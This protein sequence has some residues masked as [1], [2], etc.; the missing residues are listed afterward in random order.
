ME[1][2]VRKNERYFDIGQ[3][4]IKMGIELDYDEPTMISHVIVK[5]YMKDTLGGHINHRVRCGRE[6]HPNT[7]N[8]IFGVFCVAYRE[9]WKKLSYQ[10]FNK[11]DIVRIYNVSIEMLDLHIL[12]EFGPV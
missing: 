6:F 2:L 12:P 3:Q 9:S 4:P 7:A 11:D 8:Q 1:E 5:I 10:V